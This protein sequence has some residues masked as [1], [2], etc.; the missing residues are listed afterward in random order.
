[1]ALLWVGLSTLIVLAGALA[2]RY[3]SARMARS[4]PQVI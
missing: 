4:T 3:A 1:M 2:Y